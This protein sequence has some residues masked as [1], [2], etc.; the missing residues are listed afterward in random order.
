M[1]LKLIL[2]GLLIAINTFAYIPAPE[3]A[4]G[5]AMLAV[6]ANLVRFGRADI[7]Q[8]GAQDWLLLPR[9]KMGSFGVDGALYAKKGITPTLALIPLV[10][11]SDRLNPSTRA[12]A[13]LNVFVTA[14]TGLTDLR[15]RALAGLPRTHR[16]SRWR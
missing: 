11:I 8:A 9:G 5:V 7:D 10:W 16:A 13:A 2:L 3:D 6:A 1:R 15:L 12:V 4:D 14:I